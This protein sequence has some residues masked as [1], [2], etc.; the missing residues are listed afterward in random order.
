MGTFN[1]D[2][3]TDTSTRTLQ[4]DKIFGYENLLPE[5]G[6]KK[7]MEHVLPADHAYIDTQFQH[8]LQFS[9]LK[10]EVGI[11][12]PDKKH[13]WIAAKG[14]T[15]YENGQA[16]RILGVIMDITERKLA[17]VKLQQLSEELAAANQEN[18]ANNEKL[19][20]GNE[21]LSAVNKQLEK[22][23]ADLDTFVY[24][25]SH[26]LKSPVISLQ[27]LLTF[28][29]KK[30]T[31]KLDEKEQELLGM[32]QLSSSRLHRTIQDLTHIAKIQ[33]DTE[34]EKETI[35][36]SEVLTEIQADMNDLIKESGGKIMLLLRQK[37]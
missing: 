16:V 7:F 26:D 10:F 23:N 29:T 37:V 28:L 3:I 31:G 14:K 11:Q 2:L 18:L 1:L 6:Y 30:I 15:F 33:R 12:R 25:A 35:T 32:V 19:T 5:W 22:V 36:F 20:S 9:E 8:A 24:A 34:D 21:E 27:S 13:C 17:E 4:H